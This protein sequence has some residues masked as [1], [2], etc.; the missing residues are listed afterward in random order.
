MNTALSHA[1]EFH[2]TALVALPSGALFWPSEALLVVSDLHLG[3]SAR[4]SA[5]GGAQLPPYETRETLCKLERD[6]EACGTRRVICLGDSFDA[7]GIETAMPEDEQLWITRLMAG[8]DW[9]WIE[10]NH[11]PGPVALGGSH[12]GAL[13]LG[14][15]VFRHIATAE[16]GEISGHYHPKARLFVRG[17]SLSRPCFLV[18]GTRL[19]L[20]AYGAFTGG[21]CC[22]REP[23]AELMGHDAKAILT[24]TKA[25][26]I[27]MP[28]RA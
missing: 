28:G 10:G 18:D 3:K 6:I 2:G 19:I 22:T 26:A 20:P 17:R 15:L 23:L 16:Q 5:V 8:R 21:L 11:D 4:L 13:R 24:G 27:P 7:T 25:L 1:F 14:P 12:R 9:T